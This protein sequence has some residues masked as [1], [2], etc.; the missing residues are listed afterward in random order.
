MEI[1]RY[2]VN[3]IVQRVLVRHGV[4]LTRLRFSCTGSVVALYGELRRDPEGD[5][6]VGQIESLIR[7][8]ER[9]PYRLSLSF[10]LENWDVAYEQGNWT[11]RGRRHKITR[12]T[13]VEDL[14]VTEADALED[15]LRELEIK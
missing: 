5:F 13:P 4:D 10:D 7:E 2:E 11:I 3:Q 8:L 1:T 9:L 6:T 15:I 12:A 14:D